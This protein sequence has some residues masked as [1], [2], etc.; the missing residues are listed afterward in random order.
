MQ[1]SSQ[2]VQLPVGLCLL[3]LRALCLPEAQGA[4]AHWRAASQSCG[5]NCQGITWN[6]FDLASVQMLEEDGSWVDSAKLCKG[7]LFRT[8]HRNHFGWQPIVTCP[9]VSLMDK[10]SGACTS[11]VWPLCHHH[12]ACLVIIICTHYAC[13]HDPAS[14]T[15]AAIGKL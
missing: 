6:H 8:S 1:C 3:S 2:N 15:K 5:L 13:N 7:V 10:D 9:Q 4:L 14:P 11:V 12:H